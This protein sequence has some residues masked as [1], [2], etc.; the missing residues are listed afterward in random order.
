MVRRQLMTRAKA[1]C[2]LKCHLRHWMIIKRW[3]A[4]NNMGLDLPG[5]RKRSRV[6]MPIEAA[7]SKIV[8]LK[9]STS[10]LRSLSQPKCEKSN[11]RAQPFTTATA[12]LANPTL[13]KKQTAPNEN[14]VPYSAMGVNGVL[15]IKASTPAARTPSATASPLV[16]SERIERSRRTPN[17]GI[18]RPRHVSS[19]FAL[20]RPDK[21]VKLSR[22]M[23]NDG[24]VDITNDPDDD[25]NGDDRYL[26]SVNDPKDVN[27]SIWRIPEKTLI[28]DF[29]SK[30][31]RYIQSH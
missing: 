15:S 14:M 27:S 23:R 19:C 28:S 11:A 16:Y 8:I 26:L 31:K 13:F 25:L 2:R 20:T 4:L 6:Q 21:R 7:K 10:R 22:A 24:L 9:L 5:K 17:H 29:I 18:K 1:G 12:I 30:V 3:N